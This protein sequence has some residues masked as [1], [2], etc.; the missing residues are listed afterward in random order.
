[1]ARANPLR[2]FILAEAVVTQSEAD[3][4]TRQKY[5]SGKLSRSRLG[6]SLKECGEGKRVLKNC[7]DR[8]ECL[9]TTSRYEPRS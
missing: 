8:L 5:Q 9:E 3:E 6:T 1:M 2:D 4:F 7:V